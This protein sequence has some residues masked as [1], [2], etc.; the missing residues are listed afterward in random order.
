MKTKDPE[1]AELLTGLVAARQRGQKVL[2]Q[3]RKVEAD[4]AAFDQETEA[5][6][7]PDYENDDAVA[8]LDLLGRKRDLAA[9]KLEV[10]AG[11]DFTVR[12]ELQAMN[13]AARR[14]VNR[15]LS[16]VAEAGLKSAV[17]SLKPFFGSEDRALGAARMT[18]TCRSAHSQLACFDLDPGLMARL[19]KHLHHA[20][21]LIAVLEEAAKP[22]ADL[23]KFL[24]PAATTD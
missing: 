2:E 24:N 12:K 19:E 21:E 15:L 8:K 13:H 7:A 22:D 5:L 23:L 3:T 4:I 17:A 1:I 9:K 6:G 11:D 18:D 10:L 20:S 16:P 14:K